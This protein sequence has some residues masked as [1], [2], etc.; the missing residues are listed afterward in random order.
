MT[1]LAQ[2]T[3]LTSDPWIERV[4]LSVITCGL[5]RLLFCG[6]GFFPLCVCVLEDG[7]AGP[8]KGNNPTGNWAALSKI[9]FSHLM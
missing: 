8:E 7:V 9:Y 1:C 3:Y 4:L 6:L 5:C 2:N